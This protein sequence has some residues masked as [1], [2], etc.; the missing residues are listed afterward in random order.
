MVINDLQSFIEAIKKLIDHPLIDELTE[1]DAGVIT[2]RSSSANFIQNI[3][4]EDLRDNLIEIE[5]SASFLVF[6]KIGLL[7]P[8]VTKI[9]KKNNID[10]VRL[11]DIHK[12]FTH[13]LKT[14][15]FSILITE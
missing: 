12:P 8:H 9:L 3:D 10:I 11:S 6:D 15:K 5:D 7:K 4:E 2:L 13:A 1:E 14:S